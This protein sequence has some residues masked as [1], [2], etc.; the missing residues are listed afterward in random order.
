MAQQKNLSATT[1][2]Y[3][4]ELG[5][6]RLLLISL[7]A[8]AGQLRQE[9][10]YIVNY[11]LVDNSANDDYFKDL[12]QLGSEFEGSNSLRL[13]TIKATNNFGYSSGN[14][15]VLGQLNS[16]Y[17]LV[18]NPDVEM[19]S[20]ALCHAVDYLEKNENVVMLSPSL[21]NN[22]KSNHVVKV[23]PD[24]LTL[25]LRYLN[26]PV[27]NSCFSKRLARYNCTYL[28]DTVDNCIELAGGCFLFLSTSNFKQLGGF[29]ENFFLYF[30]DY[31]LSIRARQFGDI[32]YV[33]SVKISHV[34]GDVGRKTFQHH[35]FFLVSAIKF[36]SR[37]GWRFW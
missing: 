17:H 5:L 2:T 27:L 37:H 18:L 14:N 30:E 13:T 10:G 19:Q 3:F 21:I 33:P 11:F 23:Y 22:S 12:E 7:E 20:D 26:W 4:S 15:L 28:G 25:A 35:L 24:C 32:A 16:D 8:A 29:D 1:V 6:L 34:G 9:T 31:D 36:F